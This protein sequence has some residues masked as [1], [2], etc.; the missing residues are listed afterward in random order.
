MRSERTDA[1]RARKAGRAGRRAISSL[2]SAHRPQRAPQADFS[3]TLFRRL[4]QQRHGHLVVN[5]LQQHLAL[6]PGLGVMR[7]CSAPENHLSPAPTLKTKT[8]TRHAPRT[9][10]CRASWRRATCQPRLRLGSGRGVCLRESCVFLWSTTHP[11]IT[12]NSHSSAVSW[13]RT[14][15]GTDT[16]EPS[17]DGVPRRVMAAARAAISASTSNIEGWVR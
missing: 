14:P 12:K 4:L 6:A 9:T 15:K 10:R 13:N 8:P 7:D 16:V 17:V 2:C 1:L 5:A 11:P 3:L